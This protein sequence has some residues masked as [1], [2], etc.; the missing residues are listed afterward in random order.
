MVKLR[1][2]A[3]LVFPNP[4][5]RKE[6]LAHNAFSGSVRDPVPMRSRVGQG[7][8]MNIGQPIRE[9]E[10]EPL[11]YPAAMPEPPAEPN[12]EPGPASVPTEQPA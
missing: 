11:L 5:V 12:L 1:T 9:L 8:V 2:V 10:V 4:I 6:Y 7:G 3:P